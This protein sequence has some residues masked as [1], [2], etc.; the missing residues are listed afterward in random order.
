[1]ASDENK[2]HSL[3]LQVAEVSLQLNLQ[4]KDE[5]VFL[6]NKYA[7]HVSKPSNKYILIR[8]DI[9]S[10]R[11]KINNAKFDFKNNFISFAITS[12]RKN[13]AFFNDKFLQIFIEVINQ[14][15]GF[16]IHSSS[17]YEKSCG[18][19][20][21]GSEGA[22]KSTIRKISEPIKSLGDDVSIVRF[23]NGRFNLYG[24]PFHQRT[25][26][27][28]PNKK[29]SIRGIFNIIQN[30]YSKVEKYSDL[31]AFAKV[32]KNV[33]LSKIAES[34][35]NEI[36]FEFCKKQS[37]F[38]LDFEKNNDFRHLIKDKNLSFLEEGEFDKY[39]KNVDSGLKLSVVDRLWIPTLANQKFVDELLV[40]KE[41][42]WLFEFDGLRTVKEISKRVRNKKYFGSHTKLI[43]EKLNKSVENDMILICLKSG[44]E[45]EIIDGNH[46]TIAQTI[47]NESRIYK[48]IYADK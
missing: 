28:Y 46:G 31:D 40:V 14:N 42:S 34:Q 5:Y 11:D 9:V 47:R 18:Y 41:A 30:K 4:S 26:R 39:L 7:T 37:I 23:H 45:H 20:F 3:F 36:I 12:P 35:Q 32:R 22:G 19:I 8:I 10:S 2:H 17:L 24:S 48:L 21:M 33:F 15:R 27:S 38:K 6:K 25:K 29:V 16:V 13:F 1:M 43:L 44:N